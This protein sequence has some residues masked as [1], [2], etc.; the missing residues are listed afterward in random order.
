[1][2]FLVKFLYNCFAHF[3]LDICFFLLIYR[4]FLCAL[5]IKWVANI[6]FQ[7][8]VYLFIPL[9]SNFNEEISEF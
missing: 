3:S 4:S 8:V 1:M 7:F 6:L 2:F 9:Y 5:Y